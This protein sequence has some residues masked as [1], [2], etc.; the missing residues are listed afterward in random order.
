MAKGDKIEE[1]FNADAEIDLGNINLGETI[2]PI[3]ITPEPVQSTSYKKKVTSVLPVEDTLI[4]CLRKETIVVRYIKRQFP[5]STDPKHVFAG[6][7]ADNV[8]RCFTVPIGPNGSFVSPLTKEEQDFLEHCMGLEPRALSVY[9]K[10]DNYWENYTVRLKRTDTY[11]DLSNPTDYINY[12][13]LLTNTELI[14]SSLSAL[15]NAPKQTY[16]FVLVS[17]EEQN[18]RSNLKMNTTVNAYRLFGKMESDYSKLKF[19]V[20]TMGGKPVGAT[21]KLEFLQGQAHELLQNDPKLFV[22]IAEDKFLDIKILIFKS[23][24]KGFLKRIGDY[25]YDE[26]NQPLAAPNTDPTLSSAALYLNDVKNQ[27]LK[28]KLEAKLKV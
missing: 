2:A 10:N 23:V 4:N 6:G 26:N 18:T 3:E 16:Q 9:L 24:E 14:A 13:V 20:E 12:K 27:A 19:M 22:A 7:L 5:L 17:E 28:F 1:E 15:E 11:L 21:T 25:Y 8:S